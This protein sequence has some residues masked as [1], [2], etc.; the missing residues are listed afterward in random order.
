MARVWL[1]YDTRLDVHRAIK[2]L[3]PALMGSRSVRRRFEDEA[4]TMARLQHPHIVT[5]HDVGAEDERLFIV[6]ELVD[7]GSLMDRVRRVGALPPRLA[8]ELLA[9]VLAALAFAHQHGVVHRDVKPHNVLLSRDGA[10]KVGDFGIAHLPDRDVTRTG[11]VLGTLPY[12]APEQRRGEPT[13]PWVDVY[14]AG[15]TL[16]ALATGRDPFDLHVREYHAEAFAGLP[17]PVAELIE[18]ATRLRPDDRFKSAA[19][20]RGAVLAAAAGLPVVPDDALPRGPARLATHPALQ[21]VSHTMTPTSFSGGPR[22][23]RT[24]PTLAERDLPEVEA[25]AAPPSPAEPTMAIDADEVEATPPAAPRRREP[26]L[27]VAAVVGLA[28]VSGLLYAGSR[29]IDGPVAAEPAVAPMETVVPPADEAPATAP[30]APTEP[31]T[32]AATDAAPAKA[33]D[34]APAK[35]SDTPAPE[36]R[37]RREGV[38]RQPATPPPATPEPTP[39]EA[40][41]TATAAATET[42]RVRL[43]VNARPAGTVVVDGAEPR[44]TPY[45]VYLPPGP[46]TVRLVPGDG[47][48]GYQRTFTLVEGQPIGFCWDFQAKAPC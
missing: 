19:E 47:G 27:I 12:M 45:E 29:L 38:T 48:E 25:P 7:G 42:P 2:V 41:A 35:A 5:V 16:Y 39:P 36:A 3:E 26:T 34:A 15:A 1:A 18:R 24:G 4:R 40:A 43:F 23:L 28:A 9:D 37:P 30:V 20:M 17:A 31:A 32:D 8:C 22:R 46:H 10:V 13:G 11:A 6:M 33:T 21:G 14:A 44:R